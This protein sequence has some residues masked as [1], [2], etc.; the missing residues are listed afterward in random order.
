MLKKPLH[1]FLMLGLAA[2][3]AYQFIS[4]SS[5]AEAP[6]A[7][8]PNI[9]I[10]LDAAEAAQLAKDIRSQVS[11]QLAE[12][13]ELS[14]WAS[15]SL[16]P[17]PIAL[18][19]DQQGNAYITRTN[20]QKH[21]EFDIRGHTDWMIA[22]ISLKTVEDRRAFLRETF[23]PEKS[24]ENEWLADLN[25]DSL[26]DWRDLA[27]ETEEIFRLKDRDGDG[28]A[29]FSQVIVDDFHEEVTD[30]AGA[31]L[32]HD[33]AYFLGVAPD[34]WRLED[35]DGDGIID[36]QTSISHGYQVHI[37]FGGHGM[38]GLTV[39]P[40]GKIYWGI[41]DIGSH[42]TGP[43][44]KE[45]SQPNEGAIFR[46][47]PDGSDFEV[48][49]KGL[50][51]T[52]EF[53]FDE[54]GNI[55]SVDNDGDH[56]G[57]KERLVY[58]VEG[59]DSGWRINWQFGKYT[60]P[61]NNTYKVWMDEEMFKPRFEGQ[62]AY[63]TPPLMNY[64]SG[65]A[66]MKYNPGTALSPEWAGRF[67]VA[68]FTGSPARSN[69]YAFKLAPK[70]AGFEFVDEKTVLNGILVTGLDFGPDRSEEHTSELQSH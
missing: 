46:A 28:I 15:D 54:Y 9:T 35:T 30:V 36:K 40:D 50:R 68:E 37:G 18:A 26:H 10:E 33:G 56:P 65:P 57:E 6:A 39:G 20:R 48:F 49:A 14:L 25:G 5:A 51:N 23:A 17:D 8:K 45:W 60:D 52:H 1:A 11:V 42:I 41:G 2:S 47:N 13:L 64:H 38:S 22:S 3:F 59:S 62:A 44:G 31:M 69:V 61:D 19:F 32:P 4:C 66:G 27:V 24:K 67:F 53:T 21:S 7:K 55:I 34:M 16:A 63:I 58:I 70:G 43:D 12:G 29:D